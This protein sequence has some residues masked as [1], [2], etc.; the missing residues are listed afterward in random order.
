MG[1]LNRFDLN[2]IKKDFKIDY[3]FE[4]GTFYG[5]GVAYALQ[6]PFDKIFSVEII[7]QIAEEARNRF[8]HSSN[9]EIITSNS[10]S[11]LETVL[12]VVKGNIIFWL[13]A[14]FPGAD[15]G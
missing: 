15:A 2:R 4:T 14:H 13:D 3:F 5:E 11:A 10:F 1:R 7:P 8:N 9:I 12:P 6:T